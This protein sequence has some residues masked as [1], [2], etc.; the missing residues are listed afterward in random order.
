MHI[1]CKNDDF[2]TVK[3]LI[4]YFPYIDQKDLLGL[5][6][7]YYGFMNKNYKICTVNNLILVITL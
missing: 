5:T 7:L 2:E 3:V 4:N 6:A 1:A